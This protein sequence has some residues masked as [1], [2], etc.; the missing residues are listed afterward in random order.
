MA[1]P[2]ARADRSEASRMASWI[3]FR[4]LFGSNPFGSM[5]GLEYEVTR[6]ENDYQVDIPVPDS[7]REC[8]G[9]LSRC[10]DRGQRQKPI[11]GRSRAGPKRNH[12]ESQ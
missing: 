7:S 9:H 1:D 2:R 6:A 5:R 4:D 11:A 8:R 3:P 12:A 10:V